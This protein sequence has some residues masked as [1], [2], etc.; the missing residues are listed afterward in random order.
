MNLEQSMQMSRLSNLSKGK[1]VSAKTRTSVQIARRVF[2]LCASGGFPYTK[3]TPEKWADKFLAS[4]KFT[5]MEIDINAAASINT[6]RSEERVSH[7]MQCSSESLDPI[8]VDYNHRHKGKTKSG[9]YP[10]VVVQDG[11]HRKLS[12]LRLGHNKIMAWVGDKVINRISAAKIIDVPKGMKFE[13]QINTSD[14]KDKV[15]VLQNKVQVTGVQACGARSSGS[16]EKPDA[17]DDKVPPDASDASQS[18]DAS[19]RLQWDGNKPQ[20]YA[21]GTGPGYTDRFIIN[22]TSMGVGIIVPNPGA[23]NSD[24]ARALRLKAGGPG[25]GRKSGDKQGIPARQA[26]E[27]ERHMPK[28]KEAISKLKE[29]LRDLDVKGKGKKIDKMWQKKLNAKSL[30]ATMKAKK[31][32]SSR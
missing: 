16:L 17:S 12:R 10:K 29:S 22:T 28:T 24:T 30:K 7:Y 2:D 3:L 32:A 19:D 15:S 21:P 20:V 18:V 23:S 1:K 14:W 26:L 6:L 11:T 13:R 8:V 27:Q 4:K 25:S 5:L 9:F 31:L